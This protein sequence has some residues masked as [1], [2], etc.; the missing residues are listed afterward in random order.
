M[1]GLQGGALGRGQEV[2]TTRCADLQRWGEY[3]IPVHSVG[4]ESD[5]GYEPH[6][7]HLLAVGSLWQET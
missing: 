4:V 6:L 7:C 3:S 2:L 5:F 1:K